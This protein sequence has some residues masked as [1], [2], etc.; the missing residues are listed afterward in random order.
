MNWRIS[1]SR[2]LLHIADGLQSVPVFLMRPADLV[3][4]TRDSYARSKLVESWSSSDLVDQGL[5]INEVTLLERIPV[6]S[7]RLLLL[8]LGG[9]REAIPL[10]KQGFA[11]TG[12]DFVWEM[13]AQAK[14]NARRHHVEIEGL[15]EDLINLEVAH[16]SFDVKWFSTGSYSYIPSR[17]CRISVLKRMHTAL[18]QKGCVQAVAKPR[19]V[20]TARN[21]E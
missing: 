14:A 11:V 7:G 13:V 20:V 18:R 21:R 12:V 17:A 9:G 8:G 1:F 5:N 4:F 16:N 6:Q 2:F 15:V 19:W 10:A 3:E